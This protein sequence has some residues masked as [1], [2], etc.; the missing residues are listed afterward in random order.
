MNSTVFPPLSIFCSSFGTFP[1]AAWVLGV[2]CPDLGVFGGVKN[3]SPLEELG[4]SGGDCGDD[5]I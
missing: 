1:D 3:C 5:G 2:G 4:E